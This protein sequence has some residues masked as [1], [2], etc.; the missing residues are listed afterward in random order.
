MAWDDV[1]DFEEAVWW[2]GGSSPMDSITKA[3][4]K[5]NG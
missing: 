2:V 4:W 5:K 1:R 3:V